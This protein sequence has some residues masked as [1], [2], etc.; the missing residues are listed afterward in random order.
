MDHASLVR[1]C[2]T[3]AFVLLGVYVSVLGLIRNSGVASKR[4]WRLVPVNTSGPYTLKSGSPTF[5]VI[6]WALT[7]ALMVDLWLHG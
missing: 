3:R 6:H 1:I 4:G 2:V 5:E 7:E